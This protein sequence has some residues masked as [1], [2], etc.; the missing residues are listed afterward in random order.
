MALTRKLSTK[1]RLRGYSMK[2]RS[3]KNCPAG[4]I[5]R[6]AFVRYTRKGKHSLV[7][8]QCIRNVGA[9]GKGFRD[10]PG[11]GPLRKGELLKH[12]YV[13]VTKMSVGERHKAL[14]SAVKEFGSLSTWRKLNAVAVYSKRTAPGVSAIFKA[15]MDYIRSKYGLKEGN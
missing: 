8:E 6:A 9:P 1:T 13:G 14:D 12:G 3:L 15:D 5:K 4:Y 7:R 2:N 10:G 11:I